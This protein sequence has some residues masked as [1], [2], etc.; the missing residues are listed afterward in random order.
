MNKPILSLLLFS[1]LFSTLLLVGAVQP[2]VGS[3]KIQPELR[4]DALSAPK[5]RQTVLIVLNDAS[6]LASVDSVTN[7]LRGTVKERYAIGRVVVAEIGLDKL[8][9]LAANSA[10]KAIYPNEEVRA[11]LDFAAPQINAPTAWENGLT[12]KGV[13]IAIID[14]GIDET[15]PML[16]GKVVA[17]A[18]FSNSPYTTDSFGHGTHVAGIAAGTNA[19][20]GAFNGVAPD[21]MLL[22]AKA[23][24]DSGIGSTASVIAAINWAVENNADII[25]LSLGASFSDPQN[26]IDLAIQDA[27]ANGTIVVAAAGNCGNSCPSAGCGSFRGVGVP[28]DSLDAITVGAVDSA[29]NWACF[30]AGSNIEGVGIKPDIVAPGVNIFSSV[31]GGTQAKSGTSMSAPF[32]A[33]AAAIL[34][35]ADASMT[36]LQAKQ[37]LESNAI[38][39]GAPGKDTSFGAGVLGLENAGTPSDSNAI[40]F[41]YIFVEPAVLQNDSTEFIVKVEGRNE[42]ETVNASIT[43]PDGENVLLSMNK[44]NNGFWHALFNDTGALG[45]YLIGFEAEDASGAKANAAASFSVKTS[46]G[47]PPDYNKFL[48]VEYSFDAPD[49]ITKTIPSE[50]VLNVRLL[51]PA[52]YAAEIPPKDTVA[53]FTVKD[54][55][56]NIVDKEFVGPQE[57]YVMSDADFRFSWT[58]SMVGD[59]NI[60]ASILMEGSLAGEAEKETRVTVPG[61]SLEIT[62][63]SM[64]SSVE[65]GASAA[66]SVG[67]QQNIAIPLDGFIEVQLLDKQGELAGLAVNDGLRNNACSSD[68]EWWN[69]WWGFRKKIKICNESASETIYAASPVSFEKEA[70]DL[71]KCAE[72]FQCRQ[73]FS[74]LRVIMVN[75]Q[76]QFI[77]VP[78]GIENSDTNRVWFE[79]QKDLAPGECTSDTG[80]NS[81]W[82]YYGNLNADAPAQTDLHLPAI[83]SGLTTNALL[84]LDNSGKDSSKNRINAAHSIDSSFFVDEGVYG[85]AVKTED[86]GEYVEIPVNGTWPASSR[87]A[88]EMYVKLVYSGR[89]S[90][91]LFQGLGCGEFYAESYN[92]GQMVWRINGRIVSTPTGVLKEN[93]WQHLAFVNNGSSYIIYVD[94]VFKGNTASN[95]DVFVCSTINIGRYST[96]PMI[97][98]NGLVDEVRL[99]NGAKQSFN[100]MGVAENVVPVKFSV[101]S[102]AEEKRGCLG[103]EAKKTVMRRQLSL[104]NNSAMNASQGF[105]VEISS[106]EFDLEQCIAEG[107]CMQD[108]SDARVYWMNYEGVMQE[109]PRSIGEENGKR[110]PWFELQKT[111][112]QGKCSTDAGENNY[113]LYYSDSS[114]SAPNYLEEFPM[115]V[116]DLNQSPQRIMG[117]WHLENNLEDDSG[118]GF[119]GSAGNGEIYSNAQGNFFSDYSYGPI[120]P[121][122]DKY[123]TI[124]PGLWYNV[125]HAYTLE[126]VATIQALNNPSNIL[127]TVKNCG[128][129]VYAEIHP[130]GAI[131]WDTPGGSGGVLTD[132]GIVS[133]GKTYHLAFVFD[134]SNARIYV[135]GVPSAAVAAGDMPAS[136][137]ETVIGNYYSLNYLNLNGFVDEIRLSS[138]ARTDFPSI[139]GSPLLSGFTANAL[140]E[141]P[142]DVFAPLEEDSNR[143]VDLNVPVGV[144]PGEY[145]V[146]VIVHFEDKIVSAAGTLSVVVPE[147]G[148][149]NSVALPSSVQMNESTQLE[150]DFGNSSATAKISP[151]FLAL[152]QDKNGNALKALNFGGEEIE[153]NSSR[154]YSAEFTADI[155]AG[156]IR[157]ECN[158][159][160]RCTANK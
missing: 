109:I 130:D 156:G 72:E 114:L 10:V 146:N 107:K 92:E 121:A 110:A 23:L 128:Q 26:P 148:T 59:Y 142:I 54:E 73:D 88:L 100:G 76:G 38:D 14:S 80:L 105:P 83:D 116:P 11:T 35:E 157:F 42:V 120:T 149:I 82:V 117:Y 115:P 140:E 12:G 41:T 24:D 132:A 95:G 90:N 57:I 99:S 94:G 85:K 39:L 16:Q 89:T 137:T 139:N 71:G 101:S 4:A 63:V 98:I 159:R 27:V 91:T 49:E 78:Y 46:I 13:K 97:T 40:A 33:G 61:N 37:W 125:N 22:N 118:N 135:D 111:L 160:L 145:D 18:N 65:K 119:N 155:P 64:D 133:A 48:S 84:H 93:T 31:P 43:K 68:A 77:E 127:F 6:Q 21:A 138:Y 25:N 3:L 122:N 56:G 74:D 144:A 58:D 44:D 86:N 32:V 50:M 7:S 113:W 15:N 154:V 17:A 8:N 29:N 96:T 28:G 136:C 112:L 30:S 143:V 81:Y 129:P 103:G 131:W 87:F 75:E 147:T 104:C 9:S 20:G 19:N 153:A 47:L 151:Q 158:C 45:L 106:G 134:G 1:L 126:M 150:I 51:G 34:L 2:S 70:L 123:I 152:V 102:S 141:E 108:L 79:A 66:Y 36:P 52:E 60:E 5:A 67:L 62:S 53:E 69:D 124:T 55:F